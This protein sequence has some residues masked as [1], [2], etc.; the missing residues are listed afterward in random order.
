MQ[1]TWA[2]CEV[3]DFWGPPR[4]YRIWQ[5]GDGAQELRVVTLL[6]LLHIKTY[7]NDS[8]IFLYQDGVWMWNWGYSDLQEGQV[9]TSKWI[10]IWPLYMPLPDLWCIWI[11][12]HMSQAHGNEI[13]KMTMNPEGRSQPIQWDDLGNAVQSNQVSNLT[14]S[15]EFSTSV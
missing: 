12:F 6:L 3:A 8:S 14:D 10:C 11:V 15:F 13:P 7:L 2:A 9:F 4:A 5:A 1:F